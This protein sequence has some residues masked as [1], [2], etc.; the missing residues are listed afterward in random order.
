MMQ[1][2]P[3]TRR[4]LFFFLSVN[5]S[6]A[7]EGSFKN[8]QVYYI[9]SQRRTFLSLL[10]NRRTIFKIRLTLFSFFILA[11]NGSRASG[12]A[13]FSISSFYFILFSRHFYRLPLVWC[14]ILC[15]SSQ[16]PSLQRVATWP[17]RR[18]ERRFRLMERSR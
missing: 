11:R 8:E 18:I 1:L 5:Y 13:L 12:A 6:R 15:W 3:Y 9:T 7:E 16:P 10:R 4:P 17:Q 2:P 14:L